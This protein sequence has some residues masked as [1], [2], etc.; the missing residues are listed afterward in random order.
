MHRRRIQPSRSSGASPW[1]RSSSSCSWKCTFLHA[2][3]PVPRSI[4]EA[5]L[6]EMA[7]S[8]QS[9]ESFTPIDELPDLYLQAVV[10]WRII[11][12]T[13]IPARCHRHGA[14]LG[15]RPQSGRIVEGGSTIT[16]QLAK[17]LYF[18]QEK[19]SRARRPRRSWHG[20]SRS[21]IPRTRSWSC[22]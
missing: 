1:R 2:V 3:Q 6:D 13:P 15:E 16:Q 7:A 5:G 22:M 20:P 4:E 14:R 11:G 18:T 8:I 9:S 19:C 10:A 12:S 17:N 21:S